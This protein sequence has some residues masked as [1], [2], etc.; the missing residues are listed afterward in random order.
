VALEDIPFTRAKSHIKWLEYSACGIP[1]IFSK[2]VAYSNFVKDKKTGLLVENT[3]KAW[4]R[5]IKWMI[6]N[7]QKRFK[8]AENAQREVAEKY[9]LDKNISD[10]RD[11]YYALLDRDVP[12]TVEEGPE[13]AIIIPVFNKLEY[14]KKCLIAIAA[15]TQGIDYEVLIVDNASTD[16]TSAYLREQVAKDARIRVISNKQNVGFAGANN[17][18]VKNTNAKYV[19]FLNNDTEPRAHWLEAMLA[20]VRSDPGVGAVGSKLLYPDMTIQHAGVAIVEDLKNGDPLLAQNILVGQPHDHPQTKLIIS[21][22][23]VTAACLLSPRTIFN[24]V[25]GFDEG[26]WNGYEDVDLCFRLR[27]A[28]YEVVYQPHSEVIHHESKSGP[29][30]F[31]KVSDNINRLHEKWLGKIALDFRIEANGEAVQLNDTPIKLYQPKVDSDNSEDDGR[32]L[33]S[34]I[35]LTCNALAMTK[36]CVNSVF[37]HTAYP[38]ELIFVDNGS[39]DGTVDWLKEFSGLNKNVHVIFNAENRGF[40]AGNNQGAAIARGDY[41]CLLNNDVLVADGWLED[42]IDAFDRD[43]RIGM[44]SAVT[45]KASGMQILKN[46]PYT[47]DDGFY[48]FANEWRS[49]HGGEVTPRR[50]LAGFVMLTSHAVYHQVDG[51]DEAYG[52][53]NFEDDDISLKIRAAGYALMVHDGTYIHHYGHSSFKANKIDLLESLK[54]NEK[55]FQAKWPQVDYEELLEL[56]NPLHEQH[57]R[58][59]KQASGLLEK[60]DANGAQTLYKQVWTENPLSGEALVGLAFSYLAQRDLE[61]AELFLQDAHLNFPDNAIVLNQL[62]VVKAQQNDLESAIKYFK[63]ATNLDPSYSEAHHN[64]GQVLVE[65]G[66]YDEGVKVFVNCLATDENDVI[67]LILMARF[68]LEAGRIDQASLYL[69]KAQSVDPQNEDVRDLLKFCNMP[70]NETDDLWATKNEQG[71]AF[72]NAFKDEEA[73]TC[74]KESLD[75]HESPQAMMGQALCAVRK[76]QQIRVITI[77]N[78]LI[79]KWPDYELAYN[80]LGII[81]FQNGE[82]EN[83]LSS[84]AKSIELNSTFIEA[85]RNYGLCLVESGDYKNGI[86]VF[87]EILD[88]HPDDVET[89]LIMANFYAETERWEEAGKFVQTVLLKHPENS[90]AL[91]LKKQINGQVSIEVL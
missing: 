41:I 64:L 75:L 5:A 38:F 70:Q 11:A 20:I 59:I 47:D 23:A 12:E 34:V 44:V 65:A 72:L 91:N 48:A 13:V 37:K 71:Y 10:W 45:N 16:G 85:Q 3:N 79:E 33:A 68:N 90:D 15:Y 46:I 86:D 83:A 18:A 19:L 74:F 76:K 43:Q 4:F 81:Y 73:E 50:R 56:K 29:E 9:T 42:L 2:V 36:K 27:Q 40:S 35:M 82:L 51:F 88:K 21:L 6:D 39:S 22:Q 30:R 63:K 60:G 1:A 57:P 25:D 32:P 14:T 67:A 7:P 31:K 52:L 77:L 78:K 80:Q 26:Y 69:E 24:Q 28:G 54:A 58:Q 17:Q 84:F 53:G 61:N 62:G 89:L 55:I 49:K 8:I 66:R 87:A